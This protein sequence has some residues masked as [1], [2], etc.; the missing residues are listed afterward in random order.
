MTS[1][2]VKDLCIPVCVMQCFVCWWK[3]GVEKLCPKLRRTWPFESFTTFNL[4]YYRNHI[5]ENKSSPVLHVPAQGYGGSGCCSRLIPATFCR[6]FF[7]SPEPPYLITPN[8]C[9]SLFLSFLYFYCVPCPLIPVY[10]ISF[11]FIPPLSTRT[12]TC[13]LEPCVCH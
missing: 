3:K 11:T 9:L 4:C 8:I 6:V 12:C 1:L 2:G 7:I 10:C 5:G 13:F